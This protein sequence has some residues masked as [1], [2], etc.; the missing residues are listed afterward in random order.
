[1]LALAEEKKLGAAKIMSRNTKILKH[2]TRF[3]ACYIELGFRSLFYTA[4]SWKQL[5]PENALICYSYIF[6]GKNRA[7]YLMNLIDMHG[8]TIL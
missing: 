8:E 2:S 6:H 3:S 4:N 7:T 5:Y 1:M